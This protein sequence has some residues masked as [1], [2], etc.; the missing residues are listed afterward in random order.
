MIRAAGLEL[1]V[2]ADDDAGARGCSG[3]RQVELDL[4]ALVG[5]LSRRLHD[6]GV[7]TSTERAADFA[8]ALTL[9]RPV[10]PAPAVLDCA[11]RVRV[12]A[13]AQV[14]RVRRGVLLACS[15]IRRGR[16]RRA[17]RRAS[18]VPAPPDDRPKPERDQAR[19]DAL[20]AP[21][22]AAAERPTAPRR[23]RRARESAPRSRCRW[24]WPARRSS[25]RAKQLRRARAAG[26]RAAVP[27]DVAACASRPRCDAPGAAQQ[28]ATASA[29]TCAARCA[30]AC[31]PAATRSAWRAG[32]GASRAGGWCCCATSPGRWSPTRAPTCSS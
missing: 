9:V 6:A 30:R 21:D 14:E 15:A 20:Q 16:R 11:G 2:H 24:R 13:G 3:S 18:T 10:T 17:R 29:S 31:A 12:R 25:A 7:P 1:L 4:P 22:A 5:A 32:A 8:H 26:A 27:A 28:T 23:A 19:R